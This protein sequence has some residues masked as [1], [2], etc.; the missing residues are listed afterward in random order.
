MEPSRRRHP[1][2]S[3]SSRGPWRRSERPVSRGPILPGGFGGSLGEDLFL[4]GGFGGSLGEDLFIGGRGE[5]PA[6]AVTPA[7]VVGV[8]EPGD[9]TAGLVLSLELLPGQQL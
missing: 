2:A 3:G 7:M 9:L 8:D 4:P 1:D 6:A 5:H